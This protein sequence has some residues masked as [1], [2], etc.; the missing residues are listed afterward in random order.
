MARDDAI[1]GSFIV[2]LC[3]WPED[4]ETDTEEDLKNYVMTMDSDELRHNWR[5]SV[6]ARRAKR[7]ISVPPSTYIRPNFRASVKTHHLLGEPIWK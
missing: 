6:K 5:G 7:I 4:S 3:E 2:E 1:E